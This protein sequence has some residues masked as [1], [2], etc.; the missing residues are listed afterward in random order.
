MTA[1]LLLAALLMT[2]AGLQTTAGQT[3]TAG[4]GQQSQPD[5]S[6]V[7]T[8]TD[9]DGQCRRL[10]ETDFPGMT[11]LVYVDPDCSDC[12]QLLFRLRHSS[13][14]HDLED[15]GSVTTIVVSIDTLCE[16]WGEVRAELPR[17]WLVASDENG[18][19]GMAAYGLADM[20][21]MFLLDE[22]RHVVL[23][24]PSFQQLSAF[25]KNGGCRQSQ[26]TR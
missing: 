25:L 16:R 21:A 13:L 6:A 17:R 4:G 14:L 18:L 2:V 20:P 9:G 22:K 10:S 3:L 24:N 11:L 23:S 1:R 26:Q 5:S 15:E 8:V 7:I 12:R 19:A